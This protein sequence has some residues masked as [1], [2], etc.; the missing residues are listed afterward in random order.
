MAVSNDLYYAVLAMDS[1]N[2][3]RVGEDPVAMVVPGTAV[4]NAQLRIADLQ[5]GLPANYDSVG[6]FATAYDLNGDIVISY[7]GTDAQAGIGDLADD[8]FG[9]WVS[10][11]GDYSA[12]ARS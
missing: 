8:I 11:V 12:L 4:G 9:G 3:Q 6:F 10:G 7:R 2:R 5:N 1:Y